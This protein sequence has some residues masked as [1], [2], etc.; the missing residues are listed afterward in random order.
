MAPVVD[1]EQWVN[2]YYVAVA[3]G[4]SNS[5][6]DHLTNVPN[7]VE[8]LLAFF[9][10]VSLADIAEESDLDSEDLEYQPTSTVVQQ[11]ATDLGVVLVG[12]ASRLNGEREAGK[13]VEQ[14]ISD[15]QYQADRIAISHQHILEQAAQIDLVDQ[16]FA[17]QGYQ[18]TKTWVAQVDS[19]TCEV[20]LAM[21]GSTTSFFESFGY[22]EDSMLYDGL[23]NAHPHCRCQIVFHLERIA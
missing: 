13:S 16:F 3:Q 5:A 17:A 23:A 18:V 10:N 14:I 11:Y 8:S 9:G 4:D 20:C 22:G 6:T 7:V 21:N 15:N 1:F 2:D 19:R 12:L